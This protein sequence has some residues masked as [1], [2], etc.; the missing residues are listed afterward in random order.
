MKKFT[1][2][3]TSTNTYTRNESDIFF[4]KTPSRDNL[5]SASTS[6]LQ[7]NKGLSLIDK[8]VT[9]LT[10]YRKKLITQIHKK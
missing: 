4:N 3:K 5:Y 6:F 2:K 1:I 7:N 10:N 9:I 8:N